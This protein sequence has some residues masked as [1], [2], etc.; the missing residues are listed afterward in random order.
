[1][2]LG[3]LISLTGQTGS[4]Y[5]MLLQKSALNENKLLGN[6]WW[7]GVFIFVVGEVVTAAALGFATPCILGALQSYQ[8]VVNALLAP[9]VIPGEELTMRTGICCFGLILACIFS[10]VI[11]GETKEDSYD[12]DKLQQMFSRP[13][14]IMIIV[15][16]MLTLAF[17]VLRYYW[18]RRTNRV[19]DLFS[20]GIIIA[21]T[22]TTTTLLLKAMFEL[23]HTDGSVIL[24]GLLLLATILVSGIPFAFTNVALKYYEALSVVPICNSLTQVSRIVVAGLFFNDFSY[25]TVSR[26]VFFFLSVAVVVTGTF[27]ISLFTQQEER[28]HA[29]SRRGST[30]TG[31]LSEGDIQDSSPDEPM[32]VLNRRSITQEFVHGTRSPTNKIES[33][34]QMLLMPSAQSLITNNHK[35]RSDSLSVP[36]TASTTGSF[37]SQSTRTYDTHMT[38]EDA[39]PRSIV[40]D[41]TGT[42]STKATQ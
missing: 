22:S 12:A 25:M 27:I 31:R 26:R 21:I 11:Y 1:M 40:F 6:A 16:L 2:L 24:C 5:G 15:L 14:V 37:R 18:I 9:V 4:S 20:L 36:I 17:L 39:S 35:G 23:M 28:E 42:C 33:M 10:I 7:T 32:N 41:K 29:L 3:V 13:W 8:L 38:T 30:T 19:L 34:S